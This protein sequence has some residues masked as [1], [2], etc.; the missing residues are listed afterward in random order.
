MNDITIKTCNHPKGIERVTSFIGRKGKMLYSYEFQHDN[1]IKFTSHN[2]SLA[3][4][5]KQRDWYFSFPLFQRYCDG[6]SV[7]IVSRNGLTVDNLLWDVYLKDLKIGEST[8]YYD[9]STGLNWTYTRI[10]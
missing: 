2:P 4:C 7:D 8:P 10:N 9:T 5:R 6:M 1:G 3:E